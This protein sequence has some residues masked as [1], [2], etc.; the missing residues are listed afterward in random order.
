MYVSSNVILLAKLL[1]SVFLG[2]AGRNVAAQCPAQCICNATEASCTKSSLT[3]FPVGTF[4]RSL[5]KLDISGNMITELGDYT[6]RRWMIVSLKQLNLSNNVINRIN[7]S[8]LMGQSGLEKLDLSGNKITTF[9]PQTFVYPPRL[10]WLSLANNSHL[11]VPQDA[12]LLESRSLKVLHLEYCNISKISVANLQE[13]LA[14][15]ELHL[16]HN[17]IEAIVSNI[18]GRALHL[19]NIKFLDISYNQLKKLPPE[20]IAFPNLE[21]VDMRNNEVKV[22]GEVKSTGEFYEEIRKCS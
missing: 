9:R 11:H 18:E 22:L 4:P 8:S 15:E 7:E 3:K 13:V 21:N 1:L 14:L 5:R 16:S 6:I 10:Q 12:P 19:K 20:I 2:E 17:K